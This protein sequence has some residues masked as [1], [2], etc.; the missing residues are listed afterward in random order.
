MRQPRLCPIESDP[1]ESDLAVA[2][3]CRIVFVGLDVMGG[4]S[5]QSEPSHFISDC[6]HSRL[7]TSA[8]FDPLEATDS[9][10]L[11]VMHDY[12]SARSGWCGGMRRCKGVD[13]T[14]DRLEA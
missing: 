6:W 14:L 11:C 3:A 12:Q 2:W 4:P 9:R 5:K 13:L 7:V 10:P 8:R 1:I